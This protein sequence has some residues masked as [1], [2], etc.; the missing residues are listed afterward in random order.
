MPNLLTTWPSHAQLIDHLTISRPTYWPP[1]HLTPN[2]LTTWPSHA[3]PID[4][5]TISRPTYWPPDHLMPNLLTTWP[6]H[7][8]SELWIDSMRV[9]TFLHVKS[10]YLRTGF[11]S[12]F[13]QILC[14][15]CG[16]KK[17]SEYYW[18]KKQKNPFA[19]THE[20]TH[21]PKSTQTGHAHRYVFKL[22]RVCYFVFQA[23]PV[24]L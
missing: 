16:K 19:F 2:L 13:E 3:Q 5:L 8:G 4:H 6:S 1:D 14:L 11:Q 23:S 10:L 22:L 21:F 12:N 7:M 24:H 17:G 15:L 18:I 9:Y 20:F